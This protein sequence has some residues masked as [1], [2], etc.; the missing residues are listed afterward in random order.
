MSIPTLT[1]TPASAANAYARV[2]N[3]GDTDT[4]D[5][6]EAF[7]GVLARAIQGVADVGHKADAESIKAISGDG[8]LTDLATAVSRAE[9]S[10]QTAIAIR[11]RVVQ[12]YQDVSKMAI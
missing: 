10:L 7:G 4:S 2:Q 6:G 5:T 11:D 1:V 9:L 12:A 8:N 3:G